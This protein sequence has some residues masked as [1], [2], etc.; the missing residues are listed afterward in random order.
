MLFGSSSEVWQD[1]M[2][3]HHA[4]SGRI[5]QEMTLRALTV[6]DVNEH[7]EAYLDQE[8]TGLTTGTEPFSE[9]AV[10]IVVKRLRGNIRQIL[11]VYSRFPDQ[12]VNNGKK[13]SSPNSSIRF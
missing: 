1:V 12:A 10:E 8:R 2:S 13:V 9:V 5:D 7:I 6:G 11:F 4:L 3:E